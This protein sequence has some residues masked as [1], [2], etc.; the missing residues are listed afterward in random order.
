MMSEEKRR[1]V[2]AREPV[3]KMSEVNWEAS[4]FP[5]TDS[6]TSHE[7]EMRQLKILSNQIVQRNVR[8]GNEAFLRLG[9]RLRPF[10]ALWQ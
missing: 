3:A 7:A 2:R 5:I 6:Q 1:S 9:T 4:Q 8:I 10:A